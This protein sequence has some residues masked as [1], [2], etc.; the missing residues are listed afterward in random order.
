MTK[1]NSTIRHMNF[2]DSFC[3]KTLSDDH[4]RI[5]N[6]EE[7]RVRIRDRIVNFFPFS[8]ASITGSELAAKYKSIVELGKESGQ[9]NNEVFKTN[10]MNLEKIINPKNKSDDHQARPPYPLSGYVYDGL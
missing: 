3:S 10:L 9:S 5:F 4:L 1:I 7:G 2:I 6:V 8:R